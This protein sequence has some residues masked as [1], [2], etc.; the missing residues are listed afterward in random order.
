M[1]NE[2]TTIMLAQSFQDLTGQVLN[3]VILIISSLEQ[4]LVDLIS[5]SG[6]DY[7]AIPARVETLEQQQKNQAQGIGPNVTQASKTDSAGSQDDVDDL[8]S[9]LGI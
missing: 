5:R 8:L 6:H 3:R 7:N 4:S 2:L 9:Q 1:Q